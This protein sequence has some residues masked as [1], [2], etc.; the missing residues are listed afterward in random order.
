[1]PAIRSTSQR[2]ESS[3]ALWLNSRH[4]YRTAALSV[5]KKGAKTFNEGAGSRLATKA[6]CL[7]GAVFSQVILHREFAGGVMRAHIA[8]GA[9]DGALRTPRTV[10]AAEAPEN[11]AVGIGVAAIERIFVVEM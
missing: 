4:A 5:P 1:M 8:D 10:V 6:A 9:E 3:T 11:A 2:L 7:C